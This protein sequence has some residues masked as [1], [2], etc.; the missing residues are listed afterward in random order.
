MSYIKSKQ[1]IEY[2]K[3]G[4]KILGE[5][6]EKLAGMAKPGIS[7][8]EIDKE[9]ERLIKEAGGRPAFK[10]YKGKRD[11][12]PFPCTIC[13][14]VNE[15]L[16]HSIATQDKV[17]KDGD[18]LSIDVGMQYPVG[19]GEGENG[20]GFYTDTAITVPVG[21]VS[22]KT[23]QL[24]TV[25]Q[26]A[27]EI[28]IKAAKTGNSVA[29]IGKAIEDWVGPQGYGIVR[30]LVGHGVGRE[31]HEEPR[32]P[33]FYEKEMENWKLE[34]GVVIAIEPM[35]TLGDY[36]I[37]TAE[38]GWSIRTKD[39]SLCAHFEHTVIITNEGAVVATRRLGELS[40]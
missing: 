33:N 17:L 32:V 15:E 9:A 12:E 30:D 39:K 2:I 18:I 1:E 22:E 23:R 5:I 40:K 36:K 4:G 31:V 3:Q 27:L 19:S 14:S 25:T 29:D 10:G 26:K 37:E 13:A 38:D 7:T 35:I 21:E 11:K 8:L 34:P 24:L 28:G 6:L 16:V 20:N